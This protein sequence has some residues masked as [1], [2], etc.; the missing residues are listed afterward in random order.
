MSD[1]KARMNE[2]LAL[3]RKWM[4]ELPSPEEYLRIEALRTDPIW[5]PFTGRMMQ[6][7]AGIREE[8]VA[9]QE[10]RLRN[11]EPLIRQRKQ[12]LQQYYQR[13]Q[14]E[15]WLRAKPVLRVIEGG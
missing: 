5:G 8:R 2:I 10:R 4:N 11:I 14:Y 9:W 3:A 12:V 7:A 13:Q 6:A 15:A 1:D